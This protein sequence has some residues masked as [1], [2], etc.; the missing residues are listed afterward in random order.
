[1]PDMQSITTKSGAKL[2]AHFLGNYS[3]TVSYQPEKQIKLM[4]AG[5]TLFMVDTETNTEISRR[6]VGTAIYGMLRESVKT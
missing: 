3:I 5:D 1:M 2:I 6:C 4:F